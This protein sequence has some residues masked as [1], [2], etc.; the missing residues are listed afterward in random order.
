M[1]TKFTF[2]V[3][4][5]FL[6][7]LVFSSCSRSPAQTPIPSMAPSQT[8]L[9]APATISLPTPLPTSTAS[10]VNI[11]ASATEVGRIAEAFKGVT[12]SMAEAWNSGD[13]EAIQALYTDDI[14]HHD[15]TYF[16]HLVGIEAV[17]GM[18]RD[19]VDSYPNVKR[20]IINRYIGLTDS[21]LIYN[22]SGYQLGGYD[23]TQN[24]P[25]LTIFL[26]ET[27]GSLISHWTMYYGLDAMEK[28]GA[29]SR[30]LL[31]ITRSF[32]S[33]YASAWSS[34]DPITVGKLYA[35]DAVR[36]DMIFGELQEGRQAISSFAE[37]FFAEHP[38]IKL[39]F[40]QT[41]GEAQ[42]WQ[43]EPPVIGGAFYID[44]AGPTGQPCEVLG[45]VLLQTSN[46]TIIHEAH[47]YDADSLISCGCIK[48]FVKITWLLS[49][50]LEI[51][52]RSTVFVKSVR[53]ITCS[54]V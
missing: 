16:T 24:D 5:A 37:S 54:K 29:R 3:A 26:L 46:G 49:L 33:S 36:Q 34:S 41:F 38:G 53:L 48:A 11:L 50:P 23:F 35:E 8:S 45:A 22:L 42:G 28:S 31:D 12:N 14:V 44:A 40:F 47:Y 21:L 32:L 4:G 10:Q 51:S 13:L 30:I 7:G 20:Q 19:F 43:G 2:L 1:K 27:R 39:T 25:G 15:A 6:V 9:P 17:M 52:A 18:A